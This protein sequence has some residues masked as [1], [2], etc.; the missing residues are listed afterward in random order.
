MNAAEFARQR[1]AIDQRCHGHKQRTRAMA[2]LIRSA[3]AVLVVRQHRVVGYR[4]T[5]GEIV[6]VKARYRDE[7]K[8]M[9][10]M[11]RIQANN[12]AEQRVPVRAYACQ[13]CGGW[14]LTSQARQVA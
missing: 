12:W 5:T 14:H 4:M 13:H 7:A 2:H 8:A 10:A 1:Q 6:C 3:R 11:E 9:A